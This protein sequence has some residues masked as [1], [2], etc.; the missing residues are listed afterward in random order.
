[1]QV[2]V[3]ETFTSSDLSKILREQ[4]M[5]LLVNNRQIIFVSLCRVY[6][7]LWLTGSAA[8]LQELVFNFKQDVAN[9]Q[10]S[11]YFSVNERVLR[12]CQ[13]SNRKHAWNLSV[14]Q[15]KNV[16]SIYKMFVQSGRAPAMSFCDQHEQYSIS[17]DISFHTFLFFILG[18]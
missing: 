17:N 4:I 14:W 18:V 11:H 6:F 5:W 3:F 15:N 7:V 12:Q 1:M 2:L 10:A 8:A 9:Y 13:F 16:L